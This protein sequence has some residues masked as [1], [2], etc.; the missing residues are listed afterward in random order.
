[1]GLPQL[2]EFPPAATTSYPAITRN[3]RRMG[4]AATIAGTRMPVETLLDY[5]IG[6]QSVGDFL[7]DFPD[8]VTYEEA[9]AAL[10]QIKAA[11]SQGQLAT[12]IN[13]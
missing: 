10:Q 4:G 6:G 2:N 11:I 8:A 12:E 13:D 9:I 5:L 7:S 3:P 1:M